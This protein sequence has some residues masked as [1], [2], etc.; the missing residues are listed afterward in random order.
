MSLALLSFQ[1]YFMRNS[2]ISLLTI[3]TTLGIA[4]AAQAD[5]LIQCGTASWYEHGTQTATG[6]RFNPDGLTA[7]HRSLPFGSK[8]RVVVQGVTKGSASEVVVRINDNGP[9]TEKIIDLSRGSFS[10]LAPLGT[11][12]L[13]V[14]LY[15]A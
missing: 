12:V 5:T 6:E 4:S 10:K 13:S 7:A 11:G 2:I 14:C 9:F 3:A 8:V 15:K 1:Y